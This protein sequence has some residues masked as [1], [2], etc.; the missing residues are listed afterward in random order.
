M[1]DKHVVFVADQSVDR[2]DVDDLA[3]ILCFHVRN[4]IFAHHVHPLDVDVHRAVPV[5]LTQRFN[6]AAD[7]DPGV[8]E[9]DVDAAEMFDHAS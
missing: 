5:F 9:Q 2:A 6:S 1:T 8:I 7:G 3:I 4:H